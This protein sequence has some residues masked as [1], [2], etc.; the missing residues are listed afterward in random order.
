MRRHLACIGVAVLLSACTQAQGLRDT[1][2]TGYY[3]GTRSVSDVAAC[4]SAAWSNKPLHMQMVP[5]FG[6]TSIQL[7]DGADGTL[8]GLVDVLATGST[9]TAKF[10]SKSAISPA[11]SN[12]VMDCM[13]ATTSID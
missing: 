6:G 4:V 3:V 12:E 10:Y 13:H 1:R 9:T 5:L 7:H 2:A 11:Y 8:V